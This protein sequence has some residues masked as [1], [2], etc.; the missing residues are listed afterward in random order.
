M[1]YRFQYVNP[2]VRQSLKAIDMRAKYELYPAA[3]QV[4]ST[5]T[6]AVYAF[7]FTQL[8]RSIRTLLEHVHS[9]KVDYNGMYSF[10][11]MLCLN[12]MII[13]VQSV[14]MY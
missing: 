2:S 3:I 8:S 1:G 9:S 6:V 13:H 11:Y 5:K 7:I 4:C 14:L 12:V 10:K